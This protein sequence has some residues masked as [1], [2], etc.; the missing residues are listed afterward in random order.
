MIGILFLGIF[1]STTQYISAQ[2][3]EVSIESG[4]RDFVQENLSKIKS[5]SLNQYEKI[6][7]WRMT[8]VD[9][10][11]AIKTEKELQIIEGELELD[12]NRN[13]RVDRVL[14][15]EQVSLI[16]NSGQDFE[17]TGNVFL[18]KLYTALLGI[19]V[20][21]FSTPVF[22]YGIILFIIIIIIN[23]IFNQLFN[24]NNF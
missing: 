8:Q 20:F 2:E 14:N 23:K 9:T 18:L 19:F 4:D 13:E 6:D 3:V 10:W 5:F 15:E 12:D 24:R 22:F 17:K 21:V 1:F 16:N 11:K 7:V